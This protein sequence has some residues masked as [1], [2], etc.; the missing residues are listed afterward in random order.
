MHDQ[1]LKC[2]QYLLES[3]IRKRVIILWGLW[4][5]YLFLVA[6][7]LAVPMALPKSRIICELNSM[8]PFCHRCQIRACH[9]VPKAAAVV[10]TKAAVG[11]PKAAAA[12]FIPKKGVVKKTSVVGATKAQRGGKTSIR[13]RKKARGRGRGR[14]SATIK[15]NIKC[16]IKC[17]NAIN[18][19]LNREFENG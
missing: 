2:Y 17:S 12:I 10:V 3:W 13:G 19:Y 8:H 6:D 5:R 7:L 15:S 18:I 11:K 16:T 1:M 4:H 9:R 14:W